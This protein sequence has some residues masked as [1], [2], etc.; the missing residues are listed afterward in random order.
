MDTT[1]LL[2]GTW[3]GEARHGRAIVLAFLVAFLL[4]GAS[5]KASPQPAVATP[6]WSTVTPL[7]MERD[8]HTA[9]LLPL[10]GGKV[11]V[12]GGYN[13][14]YVSS[15]E[16]YDPNTNTWTTVAPLH[17]ARSEH[18]AT[19]LPNGNILVGGGAGDHGPLASTELYDLV[20]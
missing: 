8:A 3:L 15:V 6:T 9:T 19:L 1:Q 17:T 4:S 13:G 12:A 11:L 7:N 16:V 18:T 20:R 10:S 2:H 5:C 14:I